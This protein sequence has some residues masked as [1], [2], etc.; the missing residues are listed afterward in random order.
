MDEYDPATP[1]SKT[2]CV[3]MSTNDYEKQASSCTEGALSELID[4]LDKNPDSYRRVIAQRKKEEKENAG[5]LSYAKVTLPLSPL[6][7]HIAS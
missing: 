7:S 3:R 2:Y 1:V 4:Y 6:F 5:F